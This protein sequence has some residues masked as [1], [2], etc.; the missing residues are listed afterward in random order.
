MS[1]PTSM[2]RNRR[3]TRAQHHAILEREICEERKPLPKW[4]SILPPPVR[5]V[6]GSPLLT[7]AFIV[8][9]VQLYA[10]RHK[11]SSSRNLK[12]SSSIYKG[13][14]FWNDEKTL[15]VKTIYETPFARFQIHKVKA[16]Q[17]TIDDW[18][19]CDET[20][21]II[22]LVHEAETGKYILFRQKKYAIPG[23]PTL[24]TVGG[25]IEPGEEPLEAA[26][27]ELKEELQMECKDWVALGTYRTA[28]NRGAGIGH[29]FLAQN[30]AISDQQIAEIKGQHD[31][32]RQDIIRCTEDELLEIVLEGKFGE[33]KWAAAAAFALLRLRA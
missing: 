19:W 10:I 8:L 4:L 1:S 31:L 22:A 27:R 21:S 14:Q 12:S 2:E 33:I 30:A 11:G 24:A 9:I 15:A 25:L 6:I 18:L 26:K 3:P 17:D 28:S 32:E 13:T 7:V 5:K 29:L 20:D 16:G 23:P